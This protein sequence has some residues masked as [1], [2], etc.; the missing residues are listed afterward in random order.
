MSI[1]KIINLSL[2]ALFIIL[3]ISFAVIDKQ[4]IINQ[5][6]NWNLLPQPETFT[7]LYFDDHLK[8][9]SNVKVNT[10]QKFSFVIHNEEYK[11]MT[12]PYIVYTAS[13][14]GQTLI[15]LKSV[16]LQQNQYKTINEKF[17]E[18]NAVKREEVVVKLQNLNQ[19]IDFR[20]GVYN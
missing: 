16:T 8:L 15:D 17:I 12:Y 4:Q 13:A 9:P 5:M 11:T 19:Q 2:L 3:G 18:P 6:N 1:I 20:I 7:E 14:S 10:P